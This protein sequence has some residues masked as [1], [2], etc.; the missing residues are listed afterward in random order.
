VPADVA[1]GEEISFTIEG[2]LTIRDVAQPARFDV[3]ATAVSETE[4]RGT[5]VT[6]IDREAYGL[7]IPSVPMVAN[8]EEEVELYIDFAAY[9]E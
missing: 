7:H 5:A 2:V 6:T 1:A 4:V 8:V 3:V 9:A